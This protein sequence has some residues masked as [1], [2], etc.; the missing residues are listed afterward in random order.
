MTYPYKRE[1]LSIEEVDRLLNAPTTLQEKLCVWGLLQTGL[2]VSELATLARDQI[3][4]QQRAIRIR[5]KG[6]PHGKRSKV[7]VVP[8]SDRGRVLFEN[9]TLHHKSPYTTRTIQRVMK[10]VGDKARITKPL[11]PR[12]FGT[13]SRSCGFTKMAISDRFKGSSVTT[14]SAPLKFI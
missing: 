12:C 7:R 11:T 13:R 6:G 14:T 5:G 1:P 3:Q 9:F 8:M 2:W 10:S 4:W